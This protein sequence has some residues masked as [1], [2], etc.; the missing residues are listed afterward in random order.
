MESLKRKMT[1]GKIWVQSMDIIVSMLAY[2]I[3][4]NYYINVGC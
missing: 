4:I 2:S 1:W 3:V